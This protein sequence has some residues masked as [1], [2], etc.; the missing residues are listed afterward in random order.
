MSE[1]RIEKLRRGLDC[2]VF[3]NYPSQSSLAGLYK[4]SSEF[5]QAKID[6]KVRGKEGTGLSQSGADEEK[7]IKRKKKGN[8]STALF[9]LLRFTFHSLRFKSS[10]TPR[11]RS[12]PKIMSRL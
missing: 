4:S 11:S 1:K 10:I 5:C 7:W 3:Q 8:S 12:K 2:L 6:K 9:V